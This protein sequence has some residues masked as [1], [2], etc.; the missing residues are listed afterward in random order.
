VTRLEKISQKIS[1]HAGTVVVCPLH[2]TEIQP[3]RENDIHGVH[4]VYGG[5]ART[6]STSRRRRRERATHAPGWIDRRK[7]P[8][9]SVDRSCSGDCDGAWR[10]GSGE[11]M[12]CG[13]AGRWLAATAHGPYVYVRTPPPPPCGGIEDLIRLSRLC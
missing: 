12:P 2:L 3:P 5:N 4:T 9:V 7:L 1:P 8:H 6:V 13:P 11:A 10:R